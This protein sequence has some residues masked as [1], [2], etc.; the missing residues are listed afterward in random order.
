MR[1]RKFIW[2]FA[3]LI[4]LAL[5]VGAQEEPQK[6]IKHVPVKPTSA[7]SGQEMYTSYCAV[8]HGKDGKG[9][10]PAA[11]ALKARP[12]NLT[13]L[14]INNGGKFPSMKVAS[15]IRGESATPAHGTAEMPIWGQLFRSMSGG[16]ESEVQQRVANLTNYVET[17]QTK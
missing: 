9:N 11:E 17:I 10:G 13:A 5:A 7:A 8:C 1:N 16:H 14:T 6:T 3:G 12:T 2:M 15:S 4:A